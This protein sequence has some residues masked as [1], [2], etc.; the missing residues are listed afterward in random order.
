M[1][2]EKNIFVTGCAGFIGFHLTRRLLNEGYNVIG[3]DQINHYYDPKLKLDRLALLK[4]DKRF[5]FIKGSL[6]N[7][8]MLG[9]AFDGYSFK[10]VF[11]LAAQAGV[12]YS[13]ENPDAYIQANITGFANL[14]ECCRK[15]QISHLLYASSSS[16]YG[17]NKKTPFSVDD[18]VDHP[19][20]VYAATKK[21]NELL[22]YTY[23]HLYGIPTT[24]M[25][26]FTV[27]GPWGRPD[28]A[29]YSFTKKM[30]EEKPIYL[31][32]YGNMKRDFTY[33]DDCIESMVRLFYKGPPANSPPWKIFNIG[34]NRPVEL[35]YLIQVLEQETGK[36][37]VTNYL[38]LPPGDV[39]ETYADIDELE[40]EISYRPQVSIEEGIKS[41]VKW[42]KE[43]HL[44][45]ERDP[46]QKDGEDE[47]D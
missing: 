28:M 17:N 16:V 10:T 20:S 47:T 36:K 18:R 9:H 31:Y 27:Y 44:A 19:V 41:F 29:I 14:L 25:R 32:N 6:E 11:H 13:L 21:A 1:S 42:Y 30:F 40:K 7:K 46:L 39:L 15:H 37:A 4:K 8:V 35:H 12:R 34:N 5:T 26:F 38:P 45:E 3:F 43:Y 23:S 2:D 24:G 33:I 22:A